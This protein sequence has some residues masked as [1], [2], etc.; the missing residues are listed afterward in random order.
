ML[1]WRL[2]VFMGKTARGSESLRTRLGRRP[3]AAFRGHLKIKSRASGG[4]NSEGDTG[5]SG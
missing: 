1:R 3:A 2:A 5:N 4:L